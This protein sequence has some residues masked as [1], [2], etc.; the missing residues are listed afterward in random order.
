VNEESYQKQLFKFFAREYRMAP[1][2][3]RSA[4]QFHNAVRELAES[5]KAGWNAAA[6]DDRKLDDVA[7]QVL[8]NKALD[9]RRGGCF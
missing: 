5:F 7:I 4:L 8:A 6:A 1:E 9:R 2:T 3:L